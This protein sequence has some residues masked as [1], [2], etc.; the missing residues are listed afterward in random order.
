MQQF[1]PQRVSVFEAPVLEQFLAVVR[2]KDDQAVLEQAPVGEPVAQHAEL[3]IRV[4]DLFV[5]GGDDER[6]VLRRGFVHSKTLQSVI[7]SVKFEPATAAVN[8]PRKG[9]NAE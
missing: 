4:R 8:D 5:I 6:L 7:G 3:L 1:L 9:G 2:R